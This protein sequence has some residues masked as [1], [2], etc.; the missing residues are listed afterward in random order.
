M[1][2]VD[3]GDVYPDAEGEE[4]IVV[5][6]IIDAFFEEEDGLVVLDYKTDKVTKEEQLVEKYHMQLDYYARAL[7]QITGKHVKEK[8]IYSFE[9]QKEIILY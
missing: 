3:M 5:Q 9:L 6:G 2:G 1:L 7:S 8:M 4:M